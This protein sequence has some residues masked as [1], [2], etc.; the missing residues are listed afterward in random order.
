MFQYKAVAVIVLIFVLSVLLRGTIYTEEKKQK[1]LSKTTD[2]S[3]IQTIDRKKMDVNRIS[4][5]FRNDGEFYSDHSTTGPGFEWPKGS[6]IY[7]VFSSSMWIGAKVKNPTDTTKKEIRVATVGHFFSEFRPGR[8]MLDGLPEDYTLPQLRVYRVLPLLDSPVNNVDYLEWPVDQG[9]PW[10]DVNSNGIWEPYVD[11]IGIQWTKGPEYPDMITFYVY[12]DAEEAFHTGIWGQSKPLGVEV[13]QTNWAYTTSFGDYQFLRFQI[14]NKSTNTLDSTYLTFWSDPDLGD[15][16]DDCVGVDTTLDSRGKP[17]NLGYCYNGDNQDGPPGYGS[18]PPAVGFKLMQG[19]LVS[20][21]TSDTAIAFGKKWIGYKNGKISAFNFFCNPGQ[22]GCTNPDWYEPSR[23]AQTYNVMK[24]LTVTGKPWIDPNGHTTQFVF[25]GDPVTGTGWLYSHLLPP[26]DVRFTMPT[27]PLTITPGDSQEVIYAVSIDRGNNNLNS[28]T[29]LRSMSELVNLSYEYQ[30]RSTPTAQIISQNLYTPPFL[31]NVRVQDATNIT[32]TLKNRAD[33]ILGVA[34]LYDDGNHNDSLT[35]DGIWGNWISSSEDTAG[36]FLSLNIT[37]QN[38]D[39][40]FWKNVLSGITTIGRVK[41]ETYKIIKDNIND[42]KIPNPGERI[43]FQFKLKN[44]TAYNLQNL[45]VSLH[46]V[47]SPYIYNYSGHSGQISSINSNDTTSWQPD[48]Y[49]SLDISSDTPPGHE[50]K[51]VFQIYDDK[52]NT[53]SDTLSITIEGFTYQP[54]D[55]TTTQQNGISECKFGVRLVDYSKLK[56]N[57][58]NIYMKRLSDIDMRFNLVNTSINDTLLKLYPLP[59]WMGTNIP[60]TDGFVVTRGNIVTWSGP[61]SFSYSPSNRWF[62]GAKGIVANVYLGYGFIAYPTAYNFVNR[63]SG[64]SADSLRRVEIRFS[65]TQTQK[66]YRYIDGF[67]TFPLYL[68]LVK[69]PEFRPFVIDSNGTG[70]LYQDFEKYRLGIPDSG[71][72]VPFTVWEVDQRAGTNKQLDVGIVE[73]NDTLYR[74]TKYTKPDS[75]IDSTKE[76]IYY[77]NIDGRWNPS[78]QI[79]L[80]NTIPYSKR[81]DETILIF[82]TEYTDT[83][84]TIYTKRNDSLPHFDLLYSFSQRPIMYGITMRR[85]KIDTTFQEEDILSILPYYPLTE[86]DVFTFNPLKLLSVENQN[87]IPESYKLYHNYPNPFNPQTTIK[88]DLQK[89]SRVA[90]EIFNL[91]GQKIKTLVN[92]DKTAGSYTTTWNGTTDKGLYAASGIYFYR[93]KTENFSNTKKMVLMR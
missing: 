20:G 60:A 72:V 14:Y 40:I 87:Q 58:Y 83:A 15:A 39:T 29:R 3:A 65:K 5:W 82:D 74:W 51:L 66:A 23:Y 49:F 46:H 41:L 88:Y 56:D 84:K 62:T 9:A 43:L 68:R 44:H 91:L 16:F 57:Q 53:W 19:P 50:A 12:N 90:I 27:G 67:S 7:A 30:N 47:L 69:H 21:T 93:I 54:I 34:S 77:G 75:T 35:N 37:Y 13:R 81:G 17:H 79:L 52:E 28:I 18:A 26:S 42:D 1:T 4:A 6:G 31:I 8:I 61:K 64:L 36:A 32:A 55:T 63:P 86:N 24:G 92:E 33:Q 89:S 71:Y 73:R 10:I 59:D 76:Y 80:N 85:I 11:K 45:V 2:A 78:P 25:A 48:T 38:N 70:F 22:G